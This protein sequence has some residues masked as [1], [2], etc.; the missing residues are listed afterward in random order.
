M[1]EDKF[2]TFLVSLTWEEAKEFWRFIRSKKFNE[3]IESKIQ[4]KI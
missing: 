1:I 4:R 3:L 2:K